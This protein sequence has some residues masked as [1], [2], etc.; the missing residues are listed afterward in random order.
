MKRVRRRREEM[1]GIAAVMTAAAAMGVTAEE[2]GAEDAVATAETATGAITAAG[3]GEGERSVARSLFLLQFRERGKYLLAVILWINL[4]IF[5]GDDA[6]RSDQESMA[7]G[8]LDHTEVHH[9][10]VR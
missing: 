1:A 6:V 5:P 4:H 8:K 2:V 3:G 10:A 7:C 9:R